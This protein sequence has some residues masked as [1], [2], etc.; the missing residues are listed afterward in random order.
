M[1]KRIIIIITILLL[2]LLC[3]FAAFWAMNFTDTAT[4][5]DNDVTVEISVTDSWK[6]RDALSVKEIRFDGAGCPFYDDYCIKMDGLTYMIAEDDCEAVYI[7][8]LNIYYLISSEDHVKL[9]E[10]LKSYGIN[11]QRR[12]AAYGVDG[13]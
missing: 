4:A 3:V 1:K 6:L 12:T 7:P 2:L 11:E 10:I 13:G 8:E 5:I 9:H